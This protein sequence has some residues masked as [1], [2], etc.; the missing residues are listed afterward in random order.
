M[1]KKDIEKLELPAKT[2][3]K[4]QAKP[5]LSTELVIL[6]FALA[7]ALVFLDCY[8]STS[9]PG[10]NTYNRTHTFRLTARQG[11]SLAPQ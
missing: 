1:I 9:A 6:F 8:C 11:R 4:E 7:Y 10:P 2:R 5:K 3:E